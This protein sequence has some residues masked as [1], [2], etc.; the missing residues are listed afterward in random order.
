MYHAMFMEISR[1][2]GPESPQLRTA[3]KD[4]DPEPKKNLIEHVDP[5]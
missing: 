3:A 2:K 4:F 1:D 5:N